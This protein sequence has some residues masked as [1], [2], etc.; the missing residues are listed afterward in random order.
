LYKLNYKYISNRPNIKEIKEV[1]YFSDSST[2]FTEHIIFLFAVWYEYG[3]LDDLIREYMHKY[4]VLYPK[5]EI[6]KEDNFSRNMSYLLR[7]IDKRI[8]KK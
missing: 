3:Y 7:Q 1:L 8:F 4:E 6:P 2:I 5:V